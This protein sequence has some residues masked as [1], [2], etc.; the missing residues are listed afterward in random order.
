MDIQSFDISGI[1]DHWDEIRKNLAVDNPDYELSRDEIIERGLTGERI[2]KRKVQAAHIELI[3]DPASDRGPDAIRVLADSIHVGYISRNNTEQ[4]KELMYK[5]DTHGFKLEAD[6]GEYHLVRRHVDANGETVYTMTVDESL[7]D[8]RIY[9]D[10]DQGR[11][12][13]ESVSEKESSG[14]LSSLTGLFKKK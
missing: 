7:P 1:R 11:R 4:V 14:I 13:N 12:G 5:G 8:G 6:G 2:Y 10:L 9:R 3:L